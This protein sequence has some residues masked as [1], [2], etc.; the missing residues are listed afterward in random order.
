[1][2]KSPPGR[3]VGQIAIVDDDAPT[4]VA[5]ARLLRAHG[6]ACQAYSSARDFL[7]SLPSATPACLIVDVDMPEMSG[8]D[9][10]VALLKL[11]IH[12]P[13]VVITGVPDES[14]A[15]RAASLGAHTLLS[16]PVGRDA[17]MAAIDSA[18]GRRS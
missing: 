10:Q 4:R 3:S 9:L 18:I 7:A 12:I 15:A 11:G 8:L 14:V 17:L 13:T 6:I 16:K 1:M 2:A 5:L